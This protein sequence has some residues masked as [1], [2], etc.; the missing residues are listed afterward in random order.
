MATKTFLKNITIANSKAAAKFIQALE[1]AEN[2]KSKNVKF[3]KR[4][5][6]VKDKNQIKR[7]FSE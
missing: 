7:L 5:E 4:V 1:Y 6:E 3:D 2:K